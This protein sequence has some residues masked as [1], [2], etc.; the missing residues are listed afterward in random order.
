MDKGEHS[1]ESF[2]PQPNDT[3]GRRYRNLREYTDQLHLW[4]YQYRMWNSMQSFPLML[5]S[6]S[7]TGLSLPN[8]S[9]TTFTQ[10]TPTTAAP[11][12]T[13]AAPDNRRPVP[14]PGIQGQRVGTVHF[15]PPL[16]KRVAAEIID[17]IV[18]FYLKI[19][20]TVLV[21]RQMGYIRED[22]M[23][24]A[25]MDI[26]PKFDF[27]DITE[28]DVE[29]AFS[30]TS[31]LIALEIVNRMMITVFETLCLSKGIGG[32]VGGAT[33]GKRMLGLKVV[34]CIHVIPQTHGRVIV[35][36]A[37][38]IGFFS[39]LVRSVIKNFTMAFFFPACLTVFIFQHNRAAYD[40]LA[41]TIVIDARP[42]RQ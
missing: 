30:V 12:A 36:P 22:N 8:S 29:K 26:M 35:C 5:N 15:L 7:L 39:A 3:S 42:Q 23:I 20:M 16:W 1:T 25:P 10:F 18:L 14:N 11:E 17:F 2:R 28:I 19:M 13:Q 4:L 9:N 6:C 33:P 34:S 31:E 24:D 32:V 27:T 37:R 41:K 38:D 40:I 21:L